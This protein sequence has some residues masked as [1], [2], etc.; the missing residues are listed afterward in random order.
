MLSLFPSSPSSSFLSSFSSSWT[1]FAMKLGERRKDLIK[2]LLHQ[3]RK[4]TKED[5]WRCNFSACTPPTQTQLT[6]LTDPPPS[7]SS[8]TSLFSSSSSSEETAATSLLPLSSSSLS[9]SL[10]S[11]VRP[12]DIQTSSTSRVSSSFSL[13]SSS[14]PLVIFPFQRSPVRYAGH[15]H[16]ESIL[17]Q[18]YN[19]LPVRK[20]FLKAIRK[21]TNDKPSLSSLSSSPRLSKEA[22]NR[23][24]DSFS[25]FLSFFLLPIAL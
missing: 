3:Q 6:P 19:R 7:S 12:A 13:P 10:P 1:S 20:R 23:S 16:S 18:F 5:F 2:I 4:T 9:S 24:R 21:G 11:P 25:L 15:K 17:Q 14:S 8:S 22:R